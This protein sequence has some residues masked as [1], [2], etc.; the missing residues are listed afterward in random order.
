[1]AEKPAYK[2]LEKRIQEL[3]QAESERERIEETL[4]KSTS[5]IP[6]IG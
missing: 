2:E 1:M 5:W 3:E 6:V 4:R